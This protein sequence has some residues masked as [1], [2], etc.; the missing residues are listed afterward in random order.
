MQNQRKHWDGLH[1]K[2]VLDYFSADPSPFAYEI[3]ELLPP[4][5]KILELGCGTSSD[6]NYFSQLSHKVLAVDFS[7][8]AIEKNREF[9]RNDNLTFEVMDI[10][11]HLPFKSNSFNLV[12]ARLSLHYFTD[13]TT[14]EIFD[15]ITRVLK[16]G[17]LF[18]FVCKSVSDPKY[19]EGKMI[20]RDMYELEGHVRHFFSKK[21][22]EK[23][24]KEKFEIIKIEEGE[25]KFYSEVSSFIK[26]IARKI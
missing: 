24:L 15:Q 10:S 16:S 11:K 14:R 9:Y 17:G 3:A 19:G 21:Y 1:L 4:Y 2:G 22:T 26:V 13:D 6:S 23:L 5:Q 8:V 25:E 12:Y 18:A 7:D 20:E